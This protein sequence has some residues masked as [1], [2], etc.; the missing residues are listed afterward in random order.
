MKY[1]LLPVLSVSAVVLSACADVAPMKQKADA[2]KAGEQPPPQVV[3]APPPLPTLLLIAPTELRAEPVIPPGCWAKFFDEPDFRGR[4][5]LTVAGPVMLPDIH[6]PAGG[7]YWPHRVAS[8]L[9]GP[10]ARVTAFS[11][12]NFQNPLPTLNPG[13]EQTRLEGALSSAMSIASLKLECS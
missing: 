11:A 7:V 5:S 3:A 13:S 10:R 1:V 9:V 12:R 2:F 4:D 8:I 6:S